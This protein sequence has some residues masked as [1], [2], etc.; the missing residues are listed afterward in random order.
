MA[1]DET[2]MAGDANRVNDSATDRQ[3]RP[4]GDMTDEA[5]QRSKELESAIEMRPYTGVATAL[6]T[7]LGLGLILG[8]LCA[9][10]SLF[11]R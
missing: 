9:R 4:L 3:R 5:R 1:P 11:E 8:A 10:S 6:T 2:E 7:G